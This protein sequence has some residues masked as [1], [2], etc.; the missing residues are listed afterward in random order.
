MIEILINHLADKAVDNDYSDHRAILDI[1]SNHID[2]DTAD[3]LDEVMTARDCDM[4]D[5]YYKQ[6]FNDCLKLIRELRS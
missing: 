6:G 1:V 2:R 4:I 3:H 5:R